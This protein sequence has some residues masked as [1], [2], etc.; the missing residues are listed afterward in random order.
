M[1]ERDAWGG[2][3]IGEGGDGR[4][5]GGK[6][7]KCCWLR[8]QKGYGM[9]LGRGGRRSWGRSEVEVGARCEEL[10]HQASVCLHAEDAIGGLRVE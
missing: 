3:G 6:A 7:G 2:E 10:F 9:V 4:V 8:G 5:I 1:G